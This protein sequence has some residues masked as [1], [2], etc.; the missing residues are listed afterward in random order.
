MLT[1]NQRYLMKT[2]FILCI[3]FF[4]IGLQWGFSQENIAYSPG[5][6]LMVAALKDFSIKAE[7][8]RFELYPTNNIWNF[9]KLNTVT[10]AI[11]IVQFSLNDDDRFEY[12]LDSSNK[13]L[14][15]EENVVCG[16]FKLIPTNNTY[17]FLLLDQ[18][19][20]R[21]WQVQWSFDKKDRQVIRIY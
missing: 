7:K 10:G 17:N 21:V 12:E 6:S 1:F 18:I 11:T 13:L 3:F 15:A 19:N 2:K 20:G 14:I 8:P 16:R 9:L 4:I 5:D